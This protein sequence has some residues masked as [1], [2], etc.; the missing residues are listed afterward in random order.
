MFARQARPRIYAAIG[1]LA[2]ALNASAAPRVRTPKESIEL[3]PVTAD[4]RRLLTEAEILVRHI[5]QSSEDLKTLF[6]HYEEQTRNWRDFLNGQAEPGTRVYVLH[7]TGIK[8]LNEEIWNITGT[9]EYLETFHDFLHQYLKTNPS[10]GR[11][12]H[13]DY[14]NHFVSSILDA[15]AFQLLVIEPVTERLARA[16]AAKLPD[17]NW[18][19]WISTNL[20][21]GAGAS[22]AEAYFRAGL[23]RARYSRNPLDINVTEW[24]LKAVTRR[25][26]LVKAAA[27]IGIEWETVLAVIHNYIGRGALKEAALKRWLA[28]RHAEAVFDE[29]TKYYDDLQIA[30]FLPLPEAE[31]ASMPGWAIQRRTLFANVK[32]SRFI[33][34]TDVQGLGSIARRFQDHWIAR[35]ASLVELQTVYA[36]STAALEMFFA[37]T[38]ASLKSIIGKPDGIHVYRSGDDAIWF[39]PRLAGAKKKAVRELFEDLRDTG[40]EH[41]QLSFR[42]HY[43]NLIKINGDLPI[44]EGIADALTRARQ[45]LF[46]GKKKYKPVL[47]PPSRK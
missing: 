36:Q 26:R 38:Y 12:L 23:A 37:E 15:D 13:N 32:D 35:G 42:L 5:S 18:K 11:V 24:R 45:S 10:L 46:D 19:E 30:D 3:A 22:P 43:S 27:A 31:D 41:Y 6:A 33:A 1:A 44:A 28:R 39:L 21:S 2:L 8:Q 40:R 29:L 25:E 47:P 14:K 9:E 16:M 34:V 20:Y 4:C 17:W 7:Q